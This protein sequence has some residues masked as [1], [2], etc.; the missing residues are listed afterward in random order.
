MKIYDK[1]IY[2]RDESLKSVILIIVVF[3]LGFFTGFLVGGPIK[4]AVQD[5][6]NNNQI[7]NVQN[8]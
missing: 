4:Q 7:V 6:N 1:E 3:L 2:K 8:N 5:N